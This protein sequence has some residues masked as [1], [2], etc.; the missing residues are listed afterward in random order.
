[1]GT[2]VTDDQLDELAARATPFSLALLRWAPDRHQDG[3]EAIERAHQRRMVSL[4]VEGVIP[5]LCPIA[6]DTYAGMAILAEPVE[7]AQ[8]IMTADPCVQAGMMTVEVLPCF[9]FPGDTMPR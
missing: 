2:P 7:R 3:A 8:E 4:R 5:V 1:M 6:S 9:G